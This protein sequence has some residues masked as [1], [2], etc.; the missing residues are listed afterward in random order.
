MSSFVQQQRQLTMAADA[1]NRRNNVTT[2]RQRIVKQKKKNK[3]IILFS[4]RQF[5]TYQRLRHFQDEDELPTTDDHNFS[6]N[7][8]VAAKQEW[9]EKRGHFISHLSV[10]DEITN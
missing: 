9:M 3:Y 1:A 8:P 6:T 5:L 10:R 4:L 7:S 2:A